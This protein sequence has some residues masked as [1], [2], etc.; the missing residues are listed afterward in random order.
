MADSYP[1]EGCSFRISSK[2]SVLKTRIL[3]SCSYS[4]KQLTNPVT[5]ILPNK[6]SHAF[7]FKEVQLMKQ[8]FI[9]FDVS[10]HLRFLKLQWEGRHNLLLKTYMVWS[11]VQL[12]NFM[13]PAFRLLTQL[14]YLT[15]KH[16]KKERVQP[17]ARKQQCYLKMHVFSG[18]QSHWKID[19]I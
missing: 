19:I 4:W 8:G 17:E 18:V 6:N 2:V 16:I 12:K 15:M 14:A 7:H 9:T 3:I 10:L 11:A 1:E 5:W 13:P